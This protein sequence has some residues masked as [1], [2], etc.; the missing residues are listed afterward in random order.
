MSSRQTARIGAQKPRLQVKQKRYYATDGEDAATLAATY[1]NP[2]DEWQKYVLNDWLAR[3]KQDK[4]VY[5]TMVL[6]VPR[7]NGKNDII[8]DFELYKMAVCGEGVLHTA[9]QVK[10]ANK[11]FQRLA[12]IFSDPKNADLQ[13]MVV[14]I[15][16]TNGEQGIYLNNGGFIEYSARSRGASRGNTYSVLVIDEAQE[17]TDEQA[18]ALMPTLAASPSG[19]RQIIYTGTPPSPTSPGTV[20]ARLREQ[21][22]E[23]PSKSMCFHEWSVKDLPKK[24]STYDDLVKD[25]YEVNP[26]MGIR[27]D[28]DFTRDEFS[29]MSLDGFARERLGWWSEQKAACVIRE[30]VWRHSAIPSEEIPDEGKLTYGVKFS[31]DGS[32]V[33][34]SVCCTPEDG[35]SHVE[36]L[37]IHPLDDGLGWITDYLCTEDMEEVTAAIAIDGKN[38]SDALLNKLSEIYP[39]QALMLPGTKGVIASANMFKESLLDG[40]ITHWDSP[41]GEQKAL[42]NSALQAIKRPIGNEGG[43]GYGGD[44]SSAIESAALA[45]WANKT[46]KRDP[47]GGC[48]VL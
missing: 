41:N 12:A 13:E 39:C 43:W 20:F 25:V 42:D 10:T 11:A 4:P 23:N 5:I 40:S 7:Q 31:V 29:T 18:E 3:D 30:S 17:Y 26:A 2:P 14:N 48:V 37:G 1:A 47:T 44:N 16:R 24:G 6:S 15:R 32:Q 28:D 22:L 8:Q 34:L 9:H 19:Y 38:G 21:A 36:L 33:S 46:T 27:M 45:F 35:K